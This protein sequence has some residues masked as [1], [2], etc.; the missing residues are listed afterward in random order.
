MN[1]NRNAV[2]YLQLLK[3]SA[4]LVSSQDL[5]STFPQKNSGVSS[6]SAEVKLE[7]LFSVQRVLALVSK[8]VRIPWF[9][10]PPWGSQLDLGRCQAFRCMDPAL[11]LVLLD[12]SQTFL[13]PLGAG[14]LLFSMC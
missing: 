5:A 2:K 3:E 7:Q 12:V 4:S 1:K 13:S 8:D 14:Y 9:A 6:G 11:L 10:F